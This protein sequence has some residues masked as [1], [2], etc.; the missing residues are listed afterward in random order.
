MR[1]RRLALVL[2]VALLA[3]CG[4]DEAGS[5]RQAVRV[6]TVSGSSADAA[7]FIA[8][9]KGYF[10]A[11]RLDIAFE[12]FDSGA[13][14]IA[15]LGAGQLDVASGSIS[16]GLYNAIERG[17]GMKIVADKARVVAPGFQGL[18]VRKTLV[19]SGKFKDVSDLRGLKIAIPATGTAPERPLY[20]WLQKGGIDPKDVRI[21]QVAFP[22]QIPALQ[23]GSID[24]AVSIEPSLHKAVESGAA[25]RIAGTSDVFPDQQTSGILFGDRFAD[26]RETAEKFLVA[27]LKGVRFYNDALRGGKLAGARGDEVA[28]ILAKHTGTDAQ[29]FKTIVLHGVDPDGKSNVASLEADLRFWKDQGYVKGDV[30][31]RD[32]LDESLVDAAAK[33]LGPAK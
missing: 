28:R 32:A 25:E 17:V 23:N 31:V 7:M 13:R 21:E 5:G 14:M 1:T 11:E 16:A 33:R 15:P 8:V 29:L 2:T 19:D 26:D 3:G 4:D 10:K 20:L 12:R 27:Y 24:A 6:G 30:S 18:V 22:D 9:E